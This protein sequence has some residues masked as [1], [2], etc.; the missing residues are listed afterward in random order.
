MNLVPVE[1]DP[2]SAPPPQLIPVDHDPFAELSDTGASALSSLGRGLIKVPMAVGDTAQAAVTGATRLGGAAYTALGGELSPEQAQALTYPKMPWFSSQQLIDKAQDATGANLNYQ[3]KTKSGEYASAAMSYLP[4]ALS[5]TVG[6][7]QAVM[8]GVGAQLGGDL[9]AQVTDSQKAKQLGEMLG[10]AGGYMAGP[11]ALDAGG[12]LAQKLSGKPGEESGVPMNVAGFGIPGMM[13]SKPP[14]YDSIT[15]NRAMGDTYL[16]NKGQSQELFK[17]R[18]DIASQI[19]VDTKEISQHISG[20]IDDVQSDPMRSAR[21]TLPKLQAMQEKINSGT[22]N[23]ADAIDLNTDLNSQFKSN[24]YNQNAAGTVYADLGA[25]LKSI[26]A[27]AA[28]NHPEFGKAHALANNYWL[29][30]VENPFQNNSIMDKFFNPDDARQHKALDEGRITSIHD[31]TR[32]RAEGTPGR[33]GTPAELDAARRAL[34]ENLAQALSKEVINRQGSSGRVGAAIATVKSLK[35]LDV[36]GVIRNGANV[37]AGV[38][39]TPEQAALIK[40]AKSPAPRMATAEELA[41]ALAKRK[42]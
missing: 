37:I 1:H 34:P 8:V 3:P 28:E 18:D 23:L 36:G 33:I 19:P 41:A 12:S 16:A 6:V 24:Q 32:Q 42:Q 7:K 25:K 2:F 17:K 38:E 10:G 40:A 30:N 4:A 9:T 14:L 29:E 22:F 20:L 26:I 21:S 27:D 13:A 39:R 35:T 11:A 15:G 31:E 5:P